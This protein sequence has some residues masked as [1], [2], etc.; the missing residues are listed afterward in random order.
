MIPFE[1][2]IVGKATFYVSSLKGNDFRISTKPSGDNLY[3]DEF[4]FALEHPRGNPTEKTYFIYP[5]SKGHSFV[6]TKLDISYYNNY[7]LDVVVLNHK[8]LSLNCS[9]IFFISRDGAG[10]MIT[11]EDPGLKDCCKC[12]ANFSFYAC[13]VVQSGEEVKKSV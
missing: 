13:D 3:F 1:F 11:L 8:E 2:I 4:R 9:K 5:H 7:P 12:K 6:T 10:P